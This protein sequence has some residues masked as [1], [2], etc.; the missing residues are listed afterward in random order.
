MSKQG[1]LSI[2]SENIFPIIKKWLYSDHDIF[3]RELISNASDA[4]L[5]FKKLCDMGE[6]SC[7]TEETF[8]ITVTTDEKAQT[9]TISD[10]GIGMTE[11]E[12][13]KYITQIAFSGAEDFLN[14]YKDKMD[15]DQIIGHFGLGFYSSFMVA[16]QVEIHTK[17]YQDASSVLWQCDGGTTY[18]LTSGTRTNRGTDIILHVTDD[19]KSFL[20][21]STLTGIVEKYCNFMPVPIYVVD[22]SKETAEDAT[23]AEPTPINDTTPLYIKKPS[24][25][26]EEAYKSFYQKTFMD[27]NEPLFWIH[28]NMDYPFRLKGI[29]YFPKLKNDFEVV[30][31]KIKL[32]NNQVFVADN[33]KEV[34]P[35]FLLLLKG[36]IDCPDIPLNVSRSFLQ[37]DGFVQKISDY[38]IKK[39]ADKLTSLSKNDTENYKKFWDSIAPFIKYGCL[40]E[41]KFF[42]KMKDHILYKTTD[43]DYITLPDYLEK[44]KETLENKVVYIS[45]EVQQAQYINMFKENGL[46]AVYL[47]H[48]IDSPFMSHVE[49]ENS[50]VKFMRIDSDLSSA[51]KNEAIDTD[52]ETK[53]TNLFNAVLNKE[54]L[55][56]SVQNLKSKNVASMLLV[57]E[58]ARRMQEMMK[59]YGMD[60]SALP[61]S[62]AT[63]V[64][65]QNHPLITTLV[66]KDLDASTKEMLCNHLYDLALLSNQTLSP[67]AMQAFLVR[68][69]ELMLKLVESN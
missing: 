4:I 46:L 30:E 60:P 17:S 7:S 61:P 16:N 24:E 6:A 51:L 55:K 23:D 42:T 34:I 29:L 59:M 19:C 49:A 37:N 35:E 22:A 68:N 56:I 11:E 65:N 44:T 62:E 26:T 38:I 9:L 67:E 45:D 13:E 2:H 21:Y 3:V 5:K 12:I 18:E 53:I 63:L 64:L 31:G 58:E 41:Q 47:P 33:I 20:N 27:F 54:A 36:V 8:Q 28:L 40:R 52:H 39:V 25:C 50:D 14:K 10:N 66:A 69:N 15:D 48:P 43:E 57:S 1:N 32:Y